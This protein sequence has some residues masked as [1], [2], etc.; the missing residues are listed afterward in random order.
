LVDILAHRGFW[1]DPAEK[2]SI[3]ALERALRAGYGIETDLRDLAGELVVSHDPP[4]PG[5]LPLS[6]FLDLYAA[7]GSHATLALNVKADGLAPML[8]QA[9]AIRGIGRYFTFDMAIPDALHYLALGMPAFTRSSEYEEPPAFL[10]RAAGLWMDGFSSAWVPATSVAA[11]LAAGTTIALV[12]PELHHRP[13]RDAWAAWRPVFAVHRGPARIML[14]TDF[15]EEAA[16][17][18]GS[19]TVK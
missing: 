2:N 7:L 8:R 9:L 14:C 17:F 16:A 6:Q 4:L 15:P 19:A 3:G 18:F 10:D 1:R 12:S 11:R 13:H 5:A